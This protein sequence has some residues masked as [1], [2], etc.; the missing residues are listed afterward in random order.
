[1]NSR[2]SVKDPPKCY[3]GVSFVLMSTFFHFWLLEDASVG[4]PKSDPESDIVK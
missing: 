3:N 1:M 2:C 4:S